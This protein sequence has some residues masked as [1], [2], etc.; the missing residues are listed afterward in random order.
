MADRHSSSTSADGATSG[1]RVPGERGGHKER[2]GRACGQAPLLPAPLLLAPQ[3]AQPQRA[4][5]PPRARARAPSFSARAR[6]L[7]ASHG[8]QAARGPRSRRACSAQ[9]ALARRASRAAGLSAALGRRQAA[10]YAP[11]G[12]RADP[13][14]SRRRSDRVADGGTG[15][16]GGPA[17][18]SPAAVSQL[19]KSACLHTPLALSSP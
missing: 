11:S 12:G 3:P 5:P 4:R 16:G 19:C 8:P 2:R 18:G 14:L 9:R 1:L 10:K 17:G 13:G 15:R 7:A 6:P